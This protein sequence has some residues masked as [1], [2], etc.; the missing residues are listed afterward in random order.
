MSKT[1]IT[2][3]PVLKTIAAIVLVVCAALLLVSAIY[4]AVSACQTD[5][6]K[7]LVK[8]GSVK[9][10]RNGAKTACSVVSIVAT[11]LGIGAIVVLVLGAKGET[12]VGKGGKPEGGEK[13]KKEE[14][15]KSAKPVGEAKKAHN[16]QA[17][18]FLFS[19][20]FDRN[21]YG[22]VACKPDEHQ[23]MHCRNLFG[24]AD[25]DNGVEAIYKKYVNENEPDHVCKNENTLVVINDK[26]TEFEK[27]TDVLACNEKILE[28]WLQKYDPSFSNELD[29]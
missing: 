1:A 15:K 22:I 13:G 7:L 16:M 12:E 28:P 5:D 6:D 21:K 18:R 2:F 24:P 11:I 19:D 10:D 29:Q 25:N 14:E 17:F 9:E 3:T 20:D 23:M 26:S 8:T 4:L 27:S